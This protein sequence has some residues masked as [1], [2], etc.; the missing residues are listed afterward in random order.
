MLIAVVG[1][2]FGVDEDEE[3]GGDGVGED[4]SGGDDRGRHRIGDRPG[5]E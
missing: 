3:F 2:G 4:L 1:E 5:S